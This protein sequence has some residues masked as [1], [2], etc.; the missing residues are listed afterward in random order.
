MILNKHCPQCPY[1]AR[2]V[3]EAE[4]D[5]DLS[6]LDR[7]TPKVRQRYRDRG[8]FTVRQ[9]S[10]LFKPRRKRKSPP[11]RSNRHQFELQA[12]ALRTGKTYLHELPAL[13]R[14]PIELFLDF[15]GVPD[16]HR[17]YLLGLLVCQEGIATYHSFWADGG[18][19]EAEIWHQLLAKL[20]EYPDAPVYHYGGYE[21]R[22][23]A[24]LAKRH[25]TTCDALMQRLI[26]L[27]AH[28]FGKVYFPLR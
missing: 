1:R 24:T 13:A 22:A 27:N 4:R 9:L 17:Q 16:R 18:K 6:L 19:E 14:Q 20:D 23:I 21:A 28:G 2:C 11:Q 15:E 12:L 25:Q 26:N 3:A 5:D 7:M 10:Y 8:I